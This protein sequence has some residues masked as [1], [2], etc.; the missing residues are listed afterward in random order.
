MFREIILQLLKNNTNFIKKKNNNFDNII[1]NDVII[2]KN[3]FN[4]P[5]LNIISK[6]GDKT[7]NNLKFHDQPDG[8]EIFIDKDPKNKD[9]YLYVS[10]SEIHSVIGRKKGGVG[11]Y[12]FNKN[13]KLID[14]YMILKKT[15]SNCSGGKYNDLWLSCEEYS[16]GK[17]WATDPYNN[18]KPYSIPDMGSFRHEAVAYCKDNG[19]FYLTEDNFNGSIYRYKPT[20]GNLLKINNTYKYK[21]ENS[22]KTGSL[23]ICIGQKSR[24]LNNNIYTVNWKKIYNQKNINYNNHNLLRKSK[25]EG[26]VYS[27]KGFIFL[28]NQNEGIYCLNVK[29][30]RII[31][32]SNTYKNKQK[33]LDHPDNIYI[34]KN[35]NLLIA[36]DATKN[37]FLQLW[38][39]KIKY[40]KNQ[41]FPAI[42]DKQEIVRIK[43]HKG[44]ELSGLSVYKDVLMFTSQRGNNGKGIVFH[45]QGFKDL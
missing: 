33:D 21:K 42:I 11:V 4:N 1:K 10:N 2:N 16:N 37:N 14:Y 32:L 20:T 15:R 38:L 30:N 34:T 41:E 6:S 28:A 26:V 25:W 23:S 31:H 24:S 13:H 44:S 19:C 36:E 12:K 39:F 45:I 5:I 8:A 22:I 9:G 3:F 40:D 43:N 35:N 27:N 29:T 17:V 18:K 7:F